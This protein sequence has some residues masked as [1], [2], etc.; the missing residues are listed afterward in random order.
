MKVTIYV[1]GRSAERQK[2]EQLLADARRGTS[3]TLL[4]HGEAGIGKTTL[5]E[6]DAGRASDARVLRVEGIESEMEIAFGGL[7]QLLLPVLDLVDNLSDPQAASLRS[8]F[9]LSND[10]VRDHLTVGL[11]VLTLLSEAASDSPLLCL[12][13]DAQWLDQPSVDML[14]FA[15]RRLR[16]EGVVMLFAMRDGAVGAAVKGCLGSRSRV[17]TASRQPSCCPVC[18]PTLRTGSSRRP[19]G[20]RWRSSN[21]QPLSLRLSGPDAWDRKPCPKRQPGVRGWS[22]TVSWTGSASS[23]RNPGLSC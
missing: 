15:A 13:D 23:P 10:G 9:G 17:W 18:R 14:A 12:I 4:I 2:I 22:G 7:H 11:A 3:D 6:L 8:V 16:A 1:R 20:I 21:R 5:L 19:A